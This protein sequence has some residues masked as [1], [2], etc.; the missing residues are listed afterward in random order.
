MYLCTSRIY[1][2]YVMLA[3]TVASDIGSQKKQLFLSPHNPPKYRFSLPFV[4]L[5]YLTLSILFIEHKNGVFEVPQC[6]NSRSA[7][8]CVALSLDRAG[9]LVFLVL[10]S[11]RYWCKWR[12]CCI[13]ASSTAPRERTTV[14]F[15][16]RSDALFWTQGSAKNGGDLLAVVGGGDSEEFPERRKRVC[17][18][19]LL[20]QYT[21]DRDGR[22]R[23]L[24]RHTNFKEG[25]RSQNGR[26]GI[27]TMPWGQWS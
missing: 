21:A 7:S 6:T 15:H 23:K 25:K 9:P 18:I 11:V 22:D 19:R 26:Q 10:V 3:S 13:L 20:S 16:C 5:L 24:W 12:L 17:S 14:G 4:L 1:S 27:L 8:P 2:L